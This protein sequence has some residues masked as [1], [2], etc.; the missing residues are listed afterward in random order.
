MFGYISFV[1]LYFAFMTVNL[2]LCKFKRLILSKELRVR[3]LLRPLLNPDFLVCIYRDVEIR[4]LK[5]DATL[6]HN[7]SASSLILL[8]Y[9][10]GNQKSTSLLLNNN[11][12]PFIRFAHSMGDLKDYLY[13]YEV[14][15]GARKFWCNTNNLLT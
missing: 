8:C 14:R 13:L 7:P 4:I 10:W 9:N 5:V 15:G 2:A 12:M 6:L 3:G 11:E 1:C